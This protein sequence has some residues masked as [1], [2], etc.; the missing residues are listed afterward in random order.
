MTSRPMVGAWS[1]CCSS[2]IG[3][4]MS[5]EPRD[6]SDARRPARMI[7]GLLPIDSLGS[8]RRGLRRRELAGSLRRHETVTPCASISDSV[9]CSSRISCWNNGYLARMVCRCATNMYV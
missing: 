9:V 2:P 4:P 3:R 8:S 7:L 1:S 5:C 6:S